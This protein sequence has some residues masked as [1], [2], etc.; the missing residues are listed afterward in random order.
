AGKMLFL[1]DVA[2]K[3]YR[4]ERMLTHM[5]MAGKLDRV[6]G[7]V[8]GSFSYC[9]GEGEREV[10]EII[11]EMFHDAPYP[12]ATGVPAGHGDDNIILPLGVKMRLDSAVRR[13][14]LIEAPVRASGC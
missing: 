1:E 2:E 7:V 4:I 10:A 11:R 12:V 8:F 3:P 13:L 9:E 14:S 5:K 6:A